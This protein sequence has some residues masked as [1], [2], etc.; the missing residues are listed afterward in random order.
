MNNT[1]SRATTK[2]S[3]SDEIKN[4]KKSGARGRHAKKMSMNS[5]MMSDSSQDQQQLPQDTLLSDTNQQLQSDTTSISITQALGDLDVDNPTT[6]NKDCEAG[7]SPSPS[8]NA[9]E[10]QTMNSS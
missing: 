10:P 2:Q 3:G 4:Y 1:N 8:K 5:T 7:R 9:D 6:I